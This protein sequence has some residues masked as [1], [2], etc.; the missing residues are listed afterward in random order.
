MRNQIDEFHFRLR[1]SLDDADRLQHRCSRLFHD[2][3][4]PHIARVIEQC[5]DG[6]GDE[7]YQVDRLVID[8]DD[9]ALERFEPELLKRVPVELAR[10]LQAALE[11]RASTG[12]PVLPEDTVAPRRATH[13][14]TLRVAARTGPSDWTALLRYLDTGVWVAPDR[15]FNGPSG[16]LVPSPHACMMRLIQTSQLHA[17]DDAS[18]ARLALAERCLQPCARHRLIAGEDEAALRALLAWLIA[19]TC[20]PLPS[21]PDWSSLLPLGALLTLQRYPLAAQAKV[22]RGSAPAV[23]APTLRPLLFFGHQTAPTTAARSPDPS[24]DACLD[25]LLTQRLTEP[26][27]HMLRAL[28]TT[29]FG[30]PDSTRWPT[31]LTAKLRERLEAALNLPDGR[32][33][34]PATASG[35]RAS[36]SAG[37]ASRERDALAAERAMRAKQALAPTQHRPNPFVEAEPLVVAN[38]GLVLLWPMLP[39]LLQTFELI[40]A[41]NGWAPDAVRRAIALLDWLASGQTP[42]ADWRVPVPRL[43]CGLPPLPDDVQPIDWPVLDGPQQEEAD[44]WLNMTMAV[45]PGL[46][47]LSAA[48]VRAFF[49]QRT[50]MLA[51]DTK[52]LTLIV[53][54]DAT[55]VLLS[56]VPW[57]LTQITLPWL[58]SPIEVEW[59]A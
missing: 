5:D 16:G 14:D 39:R 54:R 26:M 52:H 49:L 32:P 18:K 56:Q 8:V 41:G 46:Q 51:A 9:V 57:P 25:A 33:P 40:D 48:D 58:S 21:Q 27:R 4:R 30:E 1:V 36:S 20:I 15:A 38:A 22:S 59:L 29:Q 23:I 50:G 34:S 55:D 12:V 37:Y 2:T 28:L 43:L 6:R 53:E 10:A 7:P 13:S 47:R 45:L 19:P 35:L 11:A 44:R 17:R 31:H 24:L 42:P 3:L